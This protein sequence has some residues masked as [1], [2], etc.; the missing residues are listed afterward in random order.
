MPKGMKGVLSLP[1]TMSP[2]H[3]EGFGT[4]K[5]KPGSLPRTGQRRQG[6]GPR[7]TEPDQAHFPEQGKDRA[8]KPSV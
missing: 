1:G 5:K 6:Q 8:R 3:G 4:K 2:G 7:L